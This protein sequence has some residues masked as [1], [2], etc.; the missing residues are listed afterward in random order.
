MSNYLY[1][2]MIRDLNDIGV[3]DF[4]PFITN[5]NE[6][7]PLP[8]NRILKTSSKSHSAEM[9][10]LI[11]Q[12][13][14]VA[15][16]GY[17]G[18][19][20]TYSQLQ[21]V[22]GKNTMRRDF[23][24]MMAP[25]SL[26]V[27]DEAHDAGG[28]PSSG[29]Q[30]KDGPP[31]QPNRAE[32]ARMLVDKADGVVFSSATAIK[33]PDVMD[34]YGRR[35]GMQE[36]LGSV[37]ALQAALETGGIPL[38]QASTNMLAQ[39]GFY[40]RR[41]RSYEGVDFGIK[42]IPVNRESTDGMS[43]IMGAILRFD[44]SKQEALGNL[45]KTLKSNARK[46]GIDSSIGMAGAASV[47]FTALMHNVMDQSLLARKADQLADEA[48]ASLER[49]EKPILTVSNTMGSFIS[50][51]VDDNDI[52]PGESFDANFSDILMKYL[53]RSRDVLEKD[54]DGS[55]ERRRLGDE[56]LGPEA[57]EAFEAAK[58]LIEQTELDFPVSPIDHIKQ[59]IE[60]AGYSFAEIT[61][62][63]DRLEYDGEGNTTY[64]RRSAQETSKAGKV[65]ATD[66]FNS[67]KA[68]VILLNRSGSTG[69]SLH[70]SEK[71]ADQRRRHMIVG[72]PERDINVFMQTLGRAHRTGQVVPPRI[73]LLMG[74]TPDEKRPA[75]LLEKKMASL[76]ANTTADRNAGFDTSSIP[77]FFNRYGDAVV[78]QILGEYPEI[79]AKLDFPITVSEEGVSSLDDVQENAISKV[80]G[81]L[82]LL[83]VKEQEVFYE[84]LE[85]EYN[86]FVAQQKALG[87]NQLEAEAVDLDA[88]PLAQAEVISP[89]AGVSSAFGSGVRADMVD[90]KAQSKP[91]TQLEVVNEVRSHL[92]IEPVKSIDAHDFEEADRLAQTFSR[93]LLEKVDQAADKY[94]D[95]QAVKIQ[96]NNVDP[97]KRQGSLDKVKLR[98]QR[99]KDQLTK[100][101]RF[102]LGQT[103]RLSTDN[104]R[105]FYGAITS[106]GK[107]G[108]SLD[109]MLN[110]SQGA[111]DNAK[112]SF[113]DSNPVAPSKW[114][115]R[116]SLTDAS[117][118]IVLPLSKINTDRIGAVDL[119]PATKNM[120][121]GDIMG[122]FDERQVGQ[123]RVR[124]VLRGN[125]LRAAEKYGKAGKIINATVA[126]GGVE[127]MLLLPRGYDIQQELSEAPVE[128]PSPRNVRQFLEITNN[129]G[130]IKTSDE[131]IT[132]KSSPNRD[133]YVLQTGKKQKGVTLD[134][135][136]LDALGQEFYSVSDRMEAQFPSE[137]LEEVV[138][139]IQQGR[140]QRLEAVTHLEEARELV[141]A[142]IPE[143]SWS[144]S[145]EEVIAGAGL[146]PSVDLSNLN[147]VRSRLEAALAQTTDEQRRSEVL[148]NEPLPEREA[149]TE[150]DIEDQSNASSDQG[151]IEEASVATHDGAIISEG[152]VPAPS[153]E[154]VGGW[155]Q[156]QGK[157]A[158][159]VG[160]LLE[161]AGLS[162][163]VMSDREFYLKIENEPFI[164][165]NIERHGDQ[166]M[167][168]HTL[169]EGGDAYIDSEMV[170]NLSK[171]GTLNLTET[172][173]HGPAGEL[174]GRDPSFAGMFASNLRHQGFAEAA[175]R[176]RQPEHHLEQ[177]ELAQTALGSAPHVSAQEPPP[178]GPAEPFDYHQ[179]LEQLRVN[180][181][182][183]PE[184]QRESLLRAIQVV[185]QMA[186]QVPQEAAEATQETITAG[187]LVQAAISQKDPTLDEQLVKPE[188][189]S[190]PSVDQFRVWYRAARTI[191][192]S[193]D[194]LAQISAA[195]HRAKAGTLKFDGFDSAAMQADMKEQRQ[196]TKLAA[197]IMPNAMNFLRSARQVG[198]GSRKDSGTIVEGKNYRISM[199]AGR[200]NIT[201]KSTQGSLTFNRQG[202]IENRG[203]TDQD[204]E[205]WQRL[206][207]VTPE[208]LKSLLEQQAKQSQPE[209]A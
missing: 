135:G 189:T 43:R 198:M 83:T 154:R 142:T 42:T 69:I 182:E 35:S 115:M 120:M 1:G 169:V 203:L 112:V 13:G 172:A 158:K 30:K 126:G 141:G 200:I 124:Q 155:S 184:A 93:D 7:V 47:N 85:G 192:R 105:I 78:E 54:Y 131:Q 101:N 95:Q 179:T 164:P 81:R 75:A 110:E 64:Q 195:G 208:Q 77:D 45:D 28:S 39:D 193:P 150:L 156:Q 31:Q 80:T 140:G 63:Q 90:V 49:G 128:L 174:R 109:A 127:P 17:D 104:G 61:G 152:S 176:S 143:F 178:A 8:D 130:I 177:L 91:K 187:E 144:D 26:L 50:G 207:Q 65:R 118:E 204:K 56:E 66:R 76:N 52:A 67:G 136:L 122:Q 103:V 18:V 149:Q 134:E 145:V 53:E 4:K 185:E 146:A 34:L 97:E 102:R 106:I 153:S 73:T 60:A 148:D 196:Q 20:T 68:D 199:Q 100:I 33:R 3:K 25:Q 37:G 209:M 123:R 121:G 27:M 125:L 205:R 23:L 88:R 147:E 114:E 194:K 183:L 98:I 186:G 160:K 133:E 163:A 151:D 191:G 12:G 15:G 168:Y 157:A 14:F 72:Q 113:G 201:N 129:E 92:G 74:D 166:L 40:I 206:G 159:H 44:R 16:D 9:A 29:W 19:F 86:S 175:V 84:L 5:S 55:G 32:F 119:M 167:L 51:Y 197:D 10:R 117:R 71:F 190:V 79:N 24:E 2:D 94:L 22:G 132:L 57:L 173:V 62:R 180:A 59:R 87:D 137:R 38:Q 99:Q 111:K 36:A 46:I 181:Q 170:F 138:T 70:A 48:I 161:E 21:T 162:A 188:A 116:V 202:I 41:E 82:P 108:G 107:R 58:E 171:D 139:Y 96:R 11:E 6:I 165:L 89:K